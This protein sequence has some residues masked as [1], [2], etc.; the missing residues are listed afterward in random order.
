MLTST[1]PCKLLNSIFHLATTDLIP[2][3]LDWRWSLREWSV[4][5]SRAKSGHISLPSLPWPL[6][7][8]HQSVVRSGPSQTPPVT[9]A[10]IGQG[11]SVIFYL[12]GDNNNSLDKWQV[13]APVTKLLSQESNIFFFSSNSN[14]SSMKISNISCCIFQ[15]MHCNYN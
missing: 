9:S 2:K 4:S 11:V 12:S 15:N 5:I 8:S 14:V 10:V 7:L 6:S 1:F 3:Y 13:W